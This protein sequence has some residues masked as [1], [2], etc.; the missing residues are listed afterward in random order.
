MGC[1]FTPLTLTLT[2]GYMFGIPN[3]NPAVGIRG[4][5]LATATSRIGPYY[6]SFTSCYVSSIDSFNVRIVWLVLL[7]TTIK[8]R[9]IRKRKIRSRWWVWKQFA[10]RAP[11]TDWHKGRQILVSTKLPPRVP[12][13]MSRSGVGGCAVGREGR[14]AACRCCHVHARRS[15]RGGNIVPYCLWLSMR[16]TIGRVP[17]T[18]VT[19]RILSMRWE[20]WLGGAQGECR[21]VR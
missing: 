18:I 21:R 15:M 7:T 4:L 1:G 5:L 10:P 17:G 11:R 13:Q 2:L 20:V 9:V 3:P 12:S 14:S 6:L 16:R 8:H 19:I